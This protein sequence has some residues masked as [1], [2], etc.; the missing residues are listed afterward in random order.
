MTGEN[1]KS[2][3][4]NSLPYC[5][6][7]IISFL[8]AL[9]IRTIPKAGVFLSNGFV[10]FGGNDPWYHL[11]NVEVILHNFPQFPWFDAYTSYPNGYAQLF[12][13]LF[14]MLLATII[15]V[16]GLGNPSQDLIYKVCAYYPAFLGALVV[17]PTYFAAKWVF[18]RRVGLLAA[19]LVA[20]S[21]G[22]MLSR[23]MIGFNDHHIAETLF[24]T[25]TAMFIIMALKVAREHPITFENLKNR[26]FESL[27]PA[28]PY[29]ILTGIALG[30]YSLA[31]VG[32][33]FFCFI[34]GIYLT[35]Q[36]VIDHMHKRSTDYLAVSGVV[37]FIIPLLIVLMVPNLSSR[38]LILK[39]LLAGIIAFPL[40][41]LI[42]I[43]LN[44]RKLKKY[45]YPLS[46]VALSFVVIILAKTFSP[47]AYSLIA[48]LATY[49]IRTGGGATIAEA[50]PI[51]YQN[52]VFT[53]KPLWYNFGPGIY[54]AF[55]ALLML[56]Y[57]V[58]TKK[59]TQE[60]TFLIVWTIMIIW[61]T[62]QQNRF[63]YY[64]SVNIAILA[65]Y[66]SIRILEFVGWNALVA[67]INSNIR[68]RAGL[69]KIVKF[70][71]IQH[72][73]S[74]LLI[75]LILINPT[76][77]LAMQQSKGVGG[78][79]VYWLEALDWMRYNTP[80]PGLDYYEN[81]Q[82]PPT[83][84]KFQYP[85]TAYGVMSWW[86]YGHWIEVIGRRIPNANPFQRGIG[87]RSQ[88]IDEENRPGA[89]TFFTA[90]S[91]EAATA[92]LK[93][94]DPDP[95][96][97]GARYIVSDVAMAT[98]KFYAMAAWTLDTADYYI[99]VQTNQGTRNVPGMRYFDSMEA[100]LHIFD[101]NGLKQYRLVHESPAVNSAE[102]GYKSVYNQ[103]S[104]GSIPV[105]N[106]GNVKIFE[107]VKGATI[108]G[109]ASANETVTISTTIKTGLGRTF[110][111]SQTTSGGS[112]EFTVPYS[113][114]GSVP[115]QTQFDTGPIAPYTVSYGNTVKE[116]RVSEMDVLD[117]NVVVVN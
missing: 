110:E 80:D 72:V 104:G 1:K 43:E 3:I 95:D 78:P 59:N 37:I 79:D 115:G 92:I 47:S 26:N 11:R 51:L 31:W 20:I 8:I 39:G 21:P 74:V 67:D 49:F 117:G 24:S 62:L 22:Q 106:T 36:H 45:Y 116:V 70:I 32:A 88:S 15:W 84:E 2:K 98:G 6:G 114:E 48:G 111:Y 108:K 55:I 28:L 87:G 34:I 71:K 64:L 81:Y 83:G 58:I 17:I 23:S 30:A 57:E 86:D 105:D 16:L 18:D 41:T 63:A 19:F 100:R 99:S 65:S 25:I 13:P 50:A 68:D 56:L 9:Y 96:K 90:Q 73:V 101:T 102:T 27:K 109:T 89:S 69:P 75:F 52:G 10:R 38:D 93:E 61:A 103:L 91:E 40:L 60:K 7:V 4:I 33:I 5:A 29:L 94:I 112:Y 44:K 76:C 113:T 85:D 12:A 42:S 35:V 66:F 97:A 46:I 82:I 54:L 53:L 107:Y 14:D 77:N